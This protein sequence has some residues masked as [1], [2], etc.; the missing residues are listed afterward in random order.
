MSSRISVS[1]QVGFLY[2]RYVGDPKDLW[3]WYEPY[4]PDE[5]VTCWVWSVWQRII[6]LGVLSKSYGNARRD[7]ILRSRHHAEP[8]TST[9]RFINGW[10][11]CAWQYYF[12]T[13]FPRVP[14]KSL[15]FMVSE[16]RQRGLR[17]EAK[18][19]GG[20]GCH[21]C[22]DYPVRSEER[23]VRKECRSRW[24]PYH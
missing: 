8:R 7:G 18:G 11:L 10:V 24:S 20:C 1:Q 4:F 19:N 16:L 22:I 15:D 23:R 13:I 5:Q 14:K 17:T 9:V 6:C 2:L 21:T 3:D 12:E